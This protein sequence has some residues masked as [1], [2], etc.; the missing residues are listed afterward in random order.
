MAGAE[1]SP[2]FMR[3]TPRRGVLTTILKVRVHCVTAHGGR[4][5]SLCRLAAG[6][7]DQVACGPRQYS[8][9]RI[10]D[11]LLLLAPS[12]FHTRNRFEPCFL[13]VITVAGD[14]ER[15]RRARLGAAVASGPG[16][17]LFATGARHKKNERPRLYQISPDNKTSIT[18]QLRPS[19]SA[20]E[21]GQGL[22]VSEHARGS[23]GSC[24][25]AGE[26]T[27]R[28]AAADRTTA[29]PIAAPE[30][31]RRGYEG[32]VFAVK[33]KKAAC[34]STA[35]IGVCRASV[36]PFWRVN[37]YAWMCWVAGWECKATGGACCTGRV[38]TAVPERD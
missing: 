5:A 4:T 35:I 21:K 38:S 14:T 20:V 27:A 6:G 26:K 8:R 24:E 17:H 12:L 36:E 1:V 15:Q 30:H 9:G 2:V 31:G 10:Y 33:V 18:T 16:R 29:V 11:A 34:T 23:R 25:S 28:L 37:R 32:G 13:L 3:P 7:G 19:A 22:R